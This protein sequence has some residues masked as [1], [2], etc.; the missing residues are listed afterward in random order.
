MPTAAS[1]PSHP[2]ALIADD[3]GAPAADV[4]ALVVFS[5]PAQ[6]TSTAKPARG[7]P[8]ARRRR[9]DEPPAGDD[10]PGPATLLLPKGQAG[11][12]D[13]T[14]AQL[15]AALA[16]LRA[17]GKAEEVVRIAAVPG[18]GAPLV[19][20]AGLG[21]GQDEQILS[22]DRL[23]GCAGA[24]LRHLVGRRRVAVVM[25]TADPAA[26]AAVAEGAAMGAYDFT[27]HRSKSPKPHAQ[28]P[29][30]IRLLG[31]NPRDGAAQAA[32]TRAA[33]LARAVAFARD[34]VNTGGNQLYPESFADAVLARAAALP[35]RTP[36]DVAVLDEHDL[37]EGGFGGIIGVGQGSVHPPRMVVMRYRPRA[38]SAHLAYIGKGITF[39]S[40]GLCI[41]PAGSMI[42]MKDDMAG[43][44]AVAGAV[45]AVA[46]LGVPVSLTGVLALAEN[47]P[48]GNAQRPG[49]VVTMGNGTT[50]EVINTDAE[51]RM[52]LA[53]AM[54]LAQRD[55]P[56]AMVDIATLT[57][58]A[59]VA[60]GK[61]TAAVLANDEELQGEVASAAT[62][63]GEAI[64]PMPIAQEIRATMDSLVADLK[65][66]G[67]TGSGGVMVG[68]AF[69][70][71]FAGLDGDGAA[72]PWAHVDIA[73][74][75][76]N[77]GSA[78]GFT[79]KG[80]TGYGVRTLV[81]LAEGRA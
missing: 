35:G 80:G 24:A 74:P 18:I 57:G 49:D 33:V 65:H 79:P 23:R 38:A 10:A 39:D 48:S 9:G 42:T 3:G 22:A 78:Y 17:V 50:V 26:V 8:A 31:I 81:A 58:A 27:R 28:P 67:E 70:R 1:S 14:R 16:G 11:L 34:L 61:R 36:L 2:L 13:A 64:W 56:E 15:D 12:S 25:P 72:L 32:L 5:R 53:D 55:E 6:P 62:S 43:A 45:L 21:D 68:A 4:D 60:L 30:T 29:S 46:E 69:L 77:D 7:R 71:E 52:V 40:G 20:V 63:A 37:R 59:I 19:A 54:C 41:K 76:Y 73:G 44:A 47:M 66:T 75:A 51:G